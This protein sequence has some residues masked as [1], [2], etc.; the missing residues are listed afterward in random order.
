[1]ALV[2]YHAVQGGKLPEN[3]AV[4]GDQCGAFH[5]DT[6]SLDIPPLLRTERQQLSKSISPDEVSV[7]LNMC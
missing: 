3:N 5:H 7:L 1:M 6:C 4:F 2:M